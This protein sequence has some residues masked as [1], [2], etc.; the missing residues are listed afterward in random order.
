[1]ELNIYFLQFWTILPSIADKPLCQFLSSSFKQN[2][3]VVSG[4]W[5]CHGGSPSAER[6]WFVIYCA[7]CWVKQSIARNVDYVKF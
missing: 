3:P 1:M 2:I 7:I 4:W 5:L 6:R